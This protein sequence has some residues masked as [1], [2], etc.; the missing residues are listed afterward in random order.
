MAPEDYSNLLDELYP[1][2]RKGSHALAGDDVY[3]LWKE[4]DSCER[5]LKKMQSKREYL[6]AELKQRIGSN[7]SISF[8][9][10]DGPAFASWKTQTRKAYDVQASSARV[11]RISSPENYFK[12][13]E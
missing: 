13:L 9:T 5:E 2:E 6:R 12:E 8:N 7:E 1:K 11:L 4:I 3:L 10:I